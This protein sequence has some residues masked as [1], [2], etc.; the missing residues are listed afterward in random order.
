MQPPAG[1]PVLA[2]SS[3]APRGLALSQ[4]QV[5]GPRGGSHTPSQQGPSSTFHTRLFHSSTG[6][7]SKMLLPTCSWSPP[8]PLTSR[9]AVPVALSV[10]AS[11]PAVLADPQMPS[12]YPAGVPHLLCAGRSTEVGDKQSSDPAARLKVHIATA[13]YVVGQEGRGWGGQQG[14]GLSP[15]TDVGALAECWEPKSREVERQ[16]W[17]GWEGSWPDRTR[18]CTPHHTCLSS[19]GPAAPPPSAQVLAL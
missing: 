2:Q 11:Q 1:G 16:R 18:S 15:E 13:G 17:W 8:A 19:C 7:A 6:P 9:T 5:Q 10:P 3:L 14:A 4:P 12:N